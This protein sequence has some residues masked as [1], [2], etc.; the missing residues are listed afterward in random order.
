MSHIGSL[1]RRQATSLSTRAADLGPSAMP[2][3]VANTHCLAEALQRCLCVPP[4]MTQL[5]D[6]V[7]ALCIIH[8]HMDGL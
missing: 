8:W 1:S 5:P 4:C 7:A 2:S 3:K 6:G